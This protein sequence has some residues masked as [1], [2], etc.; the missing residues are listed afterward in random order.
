MRP[1]RQAPST[2]MESLQRWGLK[3]Q[4]RLAFGVKRQTRLAFWP[5]TSRRV[6][7][8]TSSHDCSI[9]IKVRSV[10]L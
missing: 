7:E 1:Y 4:T 8:L 9:S 10:H 6:D 3:R 2:H 5:V